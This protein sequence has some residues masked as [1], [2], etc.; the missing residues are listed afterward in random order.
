MKTKN[1]PTSP[2]GGGAYILDLHLPNA[3]S[4]HPGRLGERT[5]EPDRYL[6]VGS[7][8]GPGGLAAR[9]SRHLKKEGR[10]LHWHIDYLTQVVDVAC[11]WV[12]PEGRECEI[13]SEL[14]AHP[15]TMVPI[16]GFGSTDCARCPAHLL[17]VPSQLQITCAQ[18]VPV[19]VFTR[20]G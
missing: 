12:L 5:L 9:V 7:A 14:L 13:V 6:Y 15:E 2:S 10:R 11:V 18:R 19:E 17:R 16:L 1:T 8:Y 3:I 4:L 20:P